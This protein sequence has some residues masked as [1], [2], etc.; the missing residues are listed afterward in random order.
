MS[1]ELPLKFI[2][3]DNISLLH[4][5]SCTVDIMLVV[6]LT[7][8]QLYCWIILVNW[9]CTYTA[10]PFNFQSVSH[11]ISELSVIF[12]GPTTCPSCWSR[13]ME[14]LLYKIQNIWIWLSK[15]WEPEGKILFILHGEQ[16]VSIIK[17]SYVVAFRDSITF[18]FTDIFVVWV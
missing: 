3:P 18:G 7:L 16:T 10:L 2:C 4:Y 17:T 1:L 6:L 13:V 9:I 15:G 14:T 5:V 8:C 12:G 11:P